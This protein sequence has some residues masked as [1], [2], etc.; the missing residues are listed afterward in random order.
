MVDLF[1]TRV[2]NK[3]EAFL[4]LH[5]RPSRLAWQPH[6]DGLVSRSPLHVPPPLPLLSLALHKVIREVT[7][8]IAV[9]FLCWP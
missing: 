2:N 3:V 9:I 7:Q 5:P 6:A 8:V 4:F 1:A